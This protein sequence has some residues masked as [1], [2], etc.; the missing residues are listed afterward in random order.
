MQKA[1]YS[2]LC[3]EYYILLG[4]SKNFI[5]D[6]TVLKE[7]KSLW[8]LHNYTEFPRTKYLSIIGSLFGIRNL[9]RILAYVIEHHSK[10]HR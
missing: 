4:N 9:S 7:L 1:L 6:K 8:F 3:Y 5:H 10:S 2:A